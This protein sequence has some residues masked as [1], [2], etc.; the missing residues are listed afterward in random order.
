MTT[1]PARASS[2]A[3]DQRG[4]KSQFAVDDATPCTSTMAGV[5]ASGCPTE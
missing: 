2:R 4:A 3:T 5:A 1:K